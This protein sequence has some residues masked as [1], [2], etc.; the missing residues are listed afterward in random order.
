MP[1]SLSDLAEHTG[2]L[3][4]IIGILG[5]AVA[6]GIKRTLDELKEMWKTIGEIM[7]RQMA[8]R[9]RLPVEYL[10]K[11]DLIDLKQML[12]DISVRLNIFMDDCRKG[13][14]VMGRIAQHRGGKE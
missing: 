12:S 11:D 2:T 3:I 4:A 14:C 1:T 5:A 7:D 10:R 6:Y 9:E 13:E 8:L